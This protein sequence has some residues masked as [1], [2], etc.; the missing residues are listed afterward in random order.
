VPCCGPMTGAAALLLVSLPT[1]PPCDCRPT[2][3]AVL[4]FVGLGAPDTVFALRCCR[5]RLGACSVDARQVM[6]AAVGPADYNYE[7]TLSTL[8]CVCAEA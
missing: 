7:E 3:S 5:S 6:M 8:R 2:A 1:T 4:F